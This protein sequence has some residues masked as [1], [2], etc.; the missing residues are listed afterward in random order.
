M[1]KQR[2]PRYPCKDLESALADA[3][4]IFDR[5]G[6]SAFQSAV[7]AKALGYSS[8]SGPVRRRIAALRQFGLLEDKDGQ[9]CLSSIAMTLVV[10]PSSSNEWKE[11][12]KQ[13]ALEPRL[14]QDLQHKLE[15]SEDSIAHD[16]ILDREFTEDGA[17]QC[18]KIFKATMS[19]AGIA[20]PL[21]E[22]AH[23]DNMTSQLEG[24][25]LSDSEH[26][27]TQKV[28]S[29]MKPNCLS[30]LSAAARPQV[31]QLPLSP[32][33]WARLEALFPM[34]E[35]AWDQMIALLEAMKPGLIHPLEEEQTTTTNSDDAQ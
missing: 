6:R 26:G 23:S 34:T 31:V 5:E 15:A 4:A 3:R 24:S 19:F 30:S 25:S 28:G 11:A 35:K 29:A 32:T 9:E 2:S 1:S 33:E 8:L 20:E 10:R 14:F 22:K 12:A 13:A 18:A 21:P 16:L 7:I 27:T 17:N